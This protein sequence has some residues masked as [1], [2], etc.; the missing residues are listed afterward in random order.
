[1]T[2][3]IKREYEEKVATLG[4]SDRK[5]DKMKNIYKRGVDVF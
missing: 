1:L 2:L 5:S 4:E 3:A